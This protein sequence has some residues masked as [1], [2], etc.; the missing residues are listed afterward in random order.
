MSKGPE[1]K[2]FA[3]V[4]TIQRTSRVICVDANNALLWTT[5]LVG[6]IIGSP[7]ITSDGK[8]IVVLHN[9]PS[10][11]LASVL[12]VR[13]GGAVVSQKPG[14]FLS[15]FGPSKLVAVNSADFLYWGESTEGGYANA[16]KVMHMKVEPPFE[17]HAD[18]LVESSTLVSPTLSADGS[19][20]WL[21]GK[22]ATVYSWRVTGNLGRAWKQQLPLSRRNATFRKSQTPLTLFV[23]T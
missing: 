18:F 2:S 11:G 20:M 22:D 10:D 7:Q 17:I 9:L 8:F 1:T 19:T 3:I 23:S 6:T 13:E 5:W 16:G 12:S 14:N 15:P 21:G 4:L